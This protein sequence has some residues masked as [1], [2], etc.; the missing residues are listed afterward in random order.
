MKDK[1]PC[2]IFFLPSCEQPQPSAGAAK[3]ANANLRLRDLLLRFSCDFV[4]HKFFSAHVVALWYPAIKVRRRQIWFALLQI[5]LEKKRSTSLIGREGNGDR[6]QGF[7]RLK[8][9][10]FRA[11]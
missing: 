2:V 11:A 3:N 4:T 8:S 1:V 6:P 5:Y 10:L 9:S 7:R